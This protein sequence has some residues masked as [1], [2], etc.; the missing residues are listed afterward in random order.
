MKTEVS[1]PESNGVESRPEKH[2]HK[3]FSAAQRC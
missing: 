1:E 2:L 3:V